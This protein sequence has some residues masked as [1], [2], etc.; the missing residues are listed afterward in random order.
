MPKCLNFSSVI[1]NKKSK[2]CIPKASFSPE[3]GGNIK[4]SN[5]NNEINRHGMI[6]LNP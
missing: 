1:K 4:S 2:L 3:S 6:K 5:V